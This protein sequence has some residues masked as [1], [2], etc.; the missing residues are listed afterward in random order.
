MVQPL[1]KQS[2][3]LRSGARIVTAVELGLGQ[4]LL[5]FAAD[6][7]ISATHADGHPLKL[8]AVNSALRADGAYEES[9][10]AQVDDG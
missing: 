4:R 7:G 6:R 8:S 1:T 3:Q 5:P 10:P 9:D 2:A